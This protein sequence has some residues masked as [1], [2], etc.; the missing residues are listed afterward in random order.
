MA[1]KRNQ[2]HRENAKNIRLLWKLKTDN[3]TMGMQS[4]REPLIVAGIHTASG[5][6]TLA[7]LA[8][9]R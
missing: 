2:A 6:K 4:F 5:V 1:E 8:G 3:R 7:I 9:A